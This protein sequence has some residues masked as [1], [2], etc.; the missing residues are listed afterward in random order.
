MGELEPDSPD[1][2]AGSEGLGKALQVWRGL[3]KT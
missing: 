3:K 1:A 2:A